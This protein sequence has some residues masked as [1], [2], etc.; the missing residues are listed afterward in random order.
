MKKKTKIFIGVGLVFVV[1]ILILAVL[2]FPKAKS[3]SEIAALLKPIIGAENQSMDVNVKLAVSGKETVIHT[4]MYLLKKENET[5]IVIEQEG[6]SAY[7]IDNVLYL[8]NGQ[9]FLISDN[10][11]EVNIKSID[12]DMFAQIAALYEALEITTT[13]ENEE[14]IY[15]IEVSGEDAMSLVGSVMPD[16]YKELSEIDSLRVDI[17]AKEK[18][19]TS[20]A[21]SGGAIVKGKEM[22]LEVRVDNFVI[23]ESGEYEIPDV[24]Q[25]AAQNV[26]KESLFCITKDL[27]R[28]MVAFADLSSQENIEGQV[29]I[30]VN[31]SFISF[32]KTY[33][34]SELK[35]NPSDIEN[36]SEIENLPEMIALMCTEGEISCVEENG[37]FHYKLRLD[38]R[39]MRQITESV[40]P[41][42]IEEMIKLSKGNVEIV[43]EGN[44]INSIEIGIAGSIQSL[45]SKIQSQVGI[46]FVFN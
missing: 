3:G 4:K 14:E 1:A 32:K 39:A 10:E 25:S 30:S 16:I 20:V 43:V 34:L 36:T 22:L 38:K 35:T 26:D 42:S 28:L 9:A 33:D 6:H 37:V 46:E 31:G 12:A 15:T 40:L 13:K 17:T 2:F 19:L 45:F 5:A 11:A 27:Y 24:I 7:I 44:K 29:T 21:Y 18:Q 41:S 8:E 23:L